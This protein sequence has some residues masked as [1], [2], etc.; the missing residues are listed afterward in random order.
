[1]TSGSDIEITRAHL[2]SLTIQKGAC[3][4]KRPRW[5]GNFPAVLVGFLALFLLAEQVAFAQT[6][7]PDALYRDA[8]AASERGDLAR[9]I[10]LYKQLVE[11]QPDSA[12]ARTNLGVVLAQAGN[13]DE[14]VAQYQ[15]ALKRAPK[16]FIIQLN[17]ALAWYKQGNFEEA[18]AELERLHHVQPENRQ[19]LYLLADCYL[20]IGKNQ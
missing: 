1:M 11:L 18:A 4:R 13:Y 12:E 15:Q 2:R 20:R 14:A 8:V 10:A 6:P 7:S 16:N 3:D 17:L 9:S 19:S 5:P